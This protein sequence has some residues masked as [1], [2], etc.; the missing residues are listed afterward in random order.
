MACQIPVLEIVARTLSLMESM[1]HAVRRCVSRHGP[2]VISASA[3]AKDC[4]G[5]TGSRGKVDVGMGAMNGVGDLLG[6]HDG[7]KDARD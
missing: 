7:H 4:T 1:L 5:A 2:C 6:I 3:S